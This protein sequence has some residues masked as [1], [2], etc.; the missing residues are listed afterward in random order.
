MKNYIVSFL[1]RGIVASALGPIILA[2]I[3]FILGQKGVIESLA[4]GDVVKGI[5]TSILLSF[6][7]GGISMIYTIEKLPLA[8]ASLIQSAVIYLD[9]IIIYLYNGWIPATARVIAFFTVVFFV[10]FFIIWT[11]IFLIIKNKSCQCAY[12]IE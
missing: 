1:K 6:I 2:V 5:L 3:Y 7:A 12:L 11:I 9:Y 4:V 8:H 10:G